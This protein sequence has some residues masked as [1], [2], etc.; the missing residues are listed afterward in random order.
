M[1]ERACTPAQSEP[2][3]TAAHERADPGTADDI[4]TAELVAAITA[5]ATR[6]G[7]IIACGCDPGIGAYLEWTNQATATTTRATEAHAPA[8]HEAKATDQA[9]A[10][11]T[12]SDAADQD[13]DAAGDTTHPGAASITEARTRSHARRRA[14]RVAWSWSGARRVGVAVATD[15]DRTWATRGAAGPSAHATRA[16]ARAASAWR[17]TGRSAQ[18]RV[19]TRPVT[20]PD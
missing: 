14:W 10:S 20:T 8:A 11:H 5:R 1:G 2:E 12:R 18:A 3:P 6:R 9:P 4:A 7:A 15:A 19:R 16:P 17:N 13:T